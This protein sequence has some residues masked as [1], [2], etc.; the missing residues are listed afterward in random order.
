[1]MSCPTNHQRAD[2]EKSLAALSAAAAK[3]VESTPSNNTPGPLKATRNNSNSMKQRTEDNQLHPM[4]GV[5]PFI[6]SE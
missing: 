4:Y 6:A 1:M 3:I 5:Q 2:G